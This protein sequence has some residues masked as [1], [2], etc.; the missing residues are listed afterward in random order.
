MRRR[1]AR[2]V[3]P[4]DS[5]VLCDLLE[6]VTGAYSE[7]ILDLSQ[8]TFADSSVLAEIVAC[9]ARLRRGGGALRLVVAGGP[10]QLLL[11]VTGLSE[12]FE[13]HRTR[14]TALGSPPFL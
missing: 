11:D 1:P 13:I 8:V 3:G 2:R 12:V 9:Q 10:V 5:D 6:R 4:V 14:Q 7:L